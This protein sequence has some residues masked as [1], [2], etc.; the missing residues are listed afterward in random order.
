MIA[1]VR[2]TDSR[3]SLVPPGFST[4][5]VPESAAQNC[6]TGVTPIRKMPVFMSL[7][8]AV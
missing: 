6:G 2:S 3:G 8:S 5:Y 7:L 4:P 1:P